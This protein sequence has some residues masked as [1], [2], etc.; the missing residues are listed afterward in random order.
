MRPKDSKNPSK[1]EWDGDGG[2][3]GALSIVV[4]AT[5]S[6]HRAPGRT[7]ATRVSLPIVNQLSTTFEPSS[8]L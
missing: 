4:A 8:R 5:K 6:D 1:L 3:L 7:I 2:A